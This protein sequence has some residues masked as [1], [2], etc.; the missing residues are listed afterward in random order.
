MNTPEL[1]EEPKKKKEPSFLDVAIQENNLREKIL[2]EDF[3]VSIVNQGRLVTITR[4]RDGLVK[5]FHRGTPWPRAQEFMDNLT[6][7]QLN[8]NFPKPRKQ[9]GK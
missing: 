1:K 7:A 2:K 9:K 5:E 4:K 8:D 3:D 6:G